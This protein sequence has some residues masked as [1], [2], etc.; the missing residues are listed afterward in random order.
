MAQGSVGTH[1]ALGRPAGLFRFAAAAVDCCGTVMM[2]MLMLT[3]PALCRVFREVC[4]SPR[5]RGRLQE[6]GC[7]LRFGKGGAHCGGS[8]SVCIRGLPI[9]I[10][11]LSTTETCPS[12]S[13]SSLSLRYISAADCCAAALPERAHTRRLTRV[14]CS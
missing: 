9:D 6:R 3:S 1:V 5:R 7:G 11:F 2:L 8:D 10:C 12:R 13:L 4:R 14:T